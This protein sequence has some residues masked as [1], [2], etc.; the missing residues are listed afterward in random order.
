MSAL[1]AFL[2]HWLVF[3]NLLAFVLFGLDKWKARRG[4]WRISENALMLSAL[5]GGSIGALAGMRV[6]HHKTRHKK[7]TVGVPAMLVLDVALA[8]LGRVLG[9]W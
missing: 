9:W 1:S 8:V 6:F 7:F 4:A 2:P 5:L 3:I